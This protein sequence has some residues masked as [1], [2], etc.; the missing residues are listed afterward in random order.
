MFTQFI[1]NAKALFDELAAAS[2]SVSLE[3]FNLYVFHGLQVEFKDLVTSLITKA[4]P[5]SY[6]DLHSH[7]PTFEFIHKTSLQSMEFATISAPLLPTT[8]SALVAQRQ[9]SGTFSRNRV[10]FM[11]GG[12]PIMAAIEGTSLLVPGL[13]FT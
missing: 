9:P 4:E 2:W 12:I 1:Q 10:D 5:F 7:L 8:P 13:I 3:D 6:T 11:E